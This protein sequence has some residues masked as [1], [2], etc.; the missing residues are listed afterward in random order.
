M[1]LANVNLE[2][3]VEIARDTYWVGSGVN[4]FLNR[5][6]YLRIYQGNGSVANMLVDPGPTSDFDD[7]VA[8]VTPVLGNIAK[9]NLVLHQPSGP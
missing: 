3:A 2:Q 9:V 8:K 5:N 4:S 1:E 6:S 7:L